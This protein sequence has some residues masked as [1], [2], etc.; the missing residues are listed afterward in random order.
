MVSGSDHNCNFSSTFQQQHAWSS[1]VPEWERL[2]WWSYTYTTEHIG[3]MEK[4]N[5]LFKNFLV[6]DTLKVD[7]NEK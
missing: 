4:I 5:L 6:G 2:S 7:G 3:N 1:K